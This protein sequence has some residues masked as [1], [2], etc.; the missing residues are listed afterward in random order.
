MRAATMPRLRR[1]NLDSPGITR[2][3]RGGGFQL[4]DPGG[5]TLKD[6]EVRARVDALA[7][8][9]AWQEVWINPD[10]RGHIQATGIDAA[11]RRQYRYHEDWHTQ[12]GRLKFK[13]M[14]L[15]AAALPTLRTHVIADLE[16]ETT[17]RDRILAAMARLLDL[18]FFRVGSESY[19]EQNGSYG[20]STMRR[21]HVTVKNGAL[22][23]AYPAKSGLHRVQHVVDEDIADLV[24]ALKRRRTAN[25]QLFAYKDGRFWKEVR[26]AQL[27]DYLKDRSGVDASAKDFRT[28]GATVL[29]A[30]ALAVAESGPRRRGQTAAVR[31]RAQVQAIKE[32]ARYLGN[33]P[34]V[35]RASYVDPR[36]LD[37]HSGGQT[38]G[39]EALFALGDEPTSGGPVPEP[40]EAAVLDLL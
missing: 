35:C 30:V 20:L 29:C 27:N 10:E 25:D 16:R 1:T 38:I 39:E 19:A 7:I 34:A 31:K 32:V 12:R 17:D 33:T 2:R 11:G 9:P 22:T 36:V 37:R 13:E 15:F 3:R 14:E 8:P 23:F 24:C 40:V 6:P 21:E 26:A 28:W 18:G 4:L 5:A